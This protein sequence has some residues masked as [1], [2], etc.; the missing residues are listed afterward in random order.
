[1][2]T[3]ERWRPVTGYEEVYSVSDC[4]HVK[5]KA[6]ASGTR[7]GRVLKPDLNTHGY[8]VVVLSQKG[9]LQKQKVHRLVCAAFLGPCPDGHQVN[10]KSG[11]KTDNRLENLEYLTYAQDRRHAQDVLGIS[12]A[13]LTPNM[14]RV[15]RRRRLAGESIASLSVAFFVGRTAISN[16]VNRITWKHVA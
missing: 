15:I 1:M 12:M 6:A 14:V 7:P 2:P 5:R 16:V 10:H 3:S 11:V 13:K 9:R 8:H 4:G